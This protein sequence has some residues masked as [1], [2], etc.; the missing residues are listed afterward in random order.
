MKQDRFT[1]FFKTC[2]TGSLFGAKSLFVGQP[3]EADFWREKNGYFD[4]LWRK[5]LGKTFWKSTNAVLQMKQ[6]RELNFGFNFRG[7]WIEAEGT[8]C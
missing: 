8:K 2:G 1:T 6:A 7:G 3:P 5:F 4:K